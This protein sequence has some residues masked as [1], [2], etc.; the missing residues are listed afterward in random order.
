LIAF[1]AAALPTIMNPNNNIAVAVPNNTNVGSVV[2]NAN[3]YFFSW[4]CLGCSIYLCASLLQDMMNISVSMIAA[5]VARWFALVTSTLIVLGCSIRVYK[6]ASCN[7]PD[8]GSATISEYCKRC[9]LAISLG[10]VGFVIS[11]IM[12]IFSLLQQQLTAV[13]EFLINAIFLILWCFGVSF[14]TFGA[15]PGSTI[16]NLYF[17]TWIT[18]LMSVFSFAVS[19]REFVSSRHQ[20]HTTTDDA[21]HEQQDVPPT[22]DF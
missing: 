1:W 5:K 9:K 2:V 17:S 6:A 7:D 12:T 19:F 20:H 3:L 11:T 21:H 18:F 16:G 14:I 8:D 10:V 22:A 15:S 13:N 4:S